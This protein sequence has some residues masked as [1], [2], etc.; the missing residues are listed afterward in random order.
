MEEAYDKQLRGEEYI[1]LSYDCGITRDSFGN[2]LE[3][4]IFYSIFYYPMEMS[5]QDENYRHLS[6]SSFCG[7]E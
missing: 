6:S 5:Y 7:E 4:N 1:K 2:Y 3:I